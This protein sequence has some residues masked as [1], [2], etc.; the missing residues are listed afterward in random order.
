MDKVRN[1]KVEDKLQTRSLAKRS[2]IIKMEMGWLRHAYAER[3]GL[4]Q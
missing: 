1:Q 2:Q 3:N 4:G